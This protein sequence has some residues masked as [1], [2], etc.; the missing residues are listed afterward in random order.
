[1]QLRKLLLA[2]ATI[3]AVAP[4]V[5]NASAENDALTACANAFSSR[6]ATDGSN[7]PVFKLRYRH[8]Q[9]DPVT[10]YYGRQY[11]FY[12]RAQDAKTGMALG[13]ASCSADL[14]GTVV[15]LTLNPPE[16]SAPVLAARR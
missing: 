5:S 10:D 8:S 9:S 12:L 1:M 14:H 13:R 15:A 11:T 7:A 4:A 6:V 3:A 16:A 2:A